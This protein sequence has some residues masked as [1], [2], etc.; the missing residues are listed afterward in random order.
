VTQWNAGYVA[1]VSYTA[2]F[3]REI[4]PSW[5]GFAAL[6]LGHRPPDLTRPFHWAELGCG[7]GFTV[8]MAAAC[9]PEGQFWGFDFNP[10]H[11]DNATNM[12]RAAGLSNAQFREASFEELAALPD[13]ALP[14]F[15]FVVLHGIWSWVSAEQQAHLREFLR[16]RLA[17]GGLAYISYNAMAG[18]AGMQPIQRLMKLWAALHPGAPH[19]TALGLIAF[20]QQIASTDALFFQQNP[21]LVT[22]LERLAQHD[23]RYLVHEYLNATWEPTSFDQVAAQMAEA[24]CGFIGSATLVDNMDAVAVPPG[25]GRIIS[26]T[27][28]LPMREMLRDLGAARSFRRDLYR[29][30]TD[31]PVAGEHMELLERIV[32]AGTGREHERD[33]QIATGIG[34]ATPKPEIYNPVLERL[35]EGPLGMTELRAMPPL[36]DQPMAEALQVVAFLTAGGQA[37]PASAAPPDAE[38]LAACARL[39]RLI[40]L[41]NR[42]GAAITYLAA[43][44]LGTAVAVDTV[45]AMLLEALGEATPDAA[46]LTEQI[47]RVLSQTGRSVVKDGTVISHPDAARSS[48]GETVG[49][50]LADRVPVLRRLGIMPAGA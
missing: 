28:D 5:L 39:N 40:G 46:A 7:Q 4:T 31:Q 3:Y 38:T 8:A 13:D 17:P 23:P 43:P 41:S 37:H 26:Q 20:L 32:I 25:I 42:R 15:D 29:R 49:R 34:Q 9:H 19:E 6:L 36:R 2:G 1:D 50:I 27:S 21:G 35:A 24:R 16:R 44:L 47:L 48:M 11:I 14:R 18:W 12:A 22:R 45:E 10:S 30:G 33:V